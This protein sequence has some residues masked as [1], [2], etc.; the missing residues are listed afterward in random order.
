MM[1]MAEF[2]LWMACKKE[3][4]IQHSLRRN[5]FNSGDVGVEDEKVGGE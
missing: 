1:L 2:L 3:S 4:A 5:K